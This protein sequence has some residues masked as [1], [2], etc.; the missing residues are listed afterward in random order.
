MSAGRPARLRVT[1]FAI[2]TLHAFAEECILGEDDRRD[3]GM[4]DVCAVLDA[5][6]A[7]GPYL[8][9]NAPRYLV[10]PADRADSIRRGLTDLANGEDD[11]AD[12]RRRNDPEGARY[13]RAARD[14]LSTLARRAGRIAVPA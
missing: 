3:E 2:S 8:T 6:L 10:F 1:G 4:A 5:Y 7:G 13:A 14:G 9:G 12:V 11:E